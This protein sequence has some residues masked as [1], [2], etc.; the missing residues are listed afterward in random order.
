MSVSVTTRTPPARRDR[1]RGLPLRRRRR[2][3]PAGRR[4]RAAG[5]GRV[6]GQPLR[7]AA[8][9]RCREQLRPGR[10]RCWRSSC[11][12]PGRSA[13]AMPEAQL[14][15]LAPPSW[16]EL[17]SRLVGRGTEPPAVRSAGWPARRPSWR[18]GGVRRH[19]GQRRGRACADELVALM[20]ARP[21]VDPHEPRS[22]RTL[23][24]RGA[25]RTCPSRTAPEGIT[26]PPIDEL[27]ERTSSKYALV[28]YAAKRARQINAYY[29]QLGE[30][31]L[32][33]VGP[34]VETAPQE[35]PLSIALR[36]INEGLLTHTAGDE[37]A[38]PGRA[39]PAAPSDGGRT[40]QHLPGA[41]STGRMGAVSRI[42]LGVSGGIAAYKA[43]ELLRCSPRP[44]T[45][46]AWSRPRARCSSSASRPGRRC[47]AS[48][49]PPTCGRTPTRCRTCGSAGRPTWSWSRR[50]RPT[51]WP[52]PPPGWPTTCSRT[53]CSPPAARWCW[54]RRCTPRCGS[55]RPPGPTWR[56]CAPRRVV[57]DPA[58][59][60]LTGADTGAAGCPSPPSS[61]S[62]PGC[63]PRRR[64]RAADLAGRRVVV[65]AGGTR[66]RW[67]RS[68]SSA[69]AP[70]AGRAT[71]WPGSPRPAAPR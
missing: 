51:C 4:R 7:H 59:G 33:Y 47:P 24:N 61:P 67:T 64:A 19:R 32:E 68:G 62:W 43:A 9:P 11:R 31:L 36:E 20:T 22:R 5:V 60:R 52:A 25:A 63:W 44:V 54:R 69:T 53:R 27:L 55:T 8:S 66:R 10:R 56:P 38:T 6:R 28:I 29:S 70:P 12:A 30:G 45:T 18:R 26:N 58:V 2:V 21:S 49:S 23:T 16:D 14:V 34:L 46:C 15:F 1:R 37:S 13:R 35:K 41:S 48:R 57:V 42:V 39:S 40:R 65:T 71:R 17:V 50:P 3:R